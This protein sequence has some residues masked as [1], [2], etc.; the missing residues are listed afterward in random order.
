MFCACR[1]GS[2]RPA[3]WRGATDMGVESNLRFRRWK[4]VISLEAV[5]ELREFSDTPDSIRSARRFR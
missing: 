2:A 1:R 5:S 4:H 3:G